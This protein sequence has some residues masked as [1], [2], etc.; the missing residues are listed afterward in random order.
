MSRRRWQ[1][2]YIPHRLNDVTEKLRLNASSPMQPI[3]WLAAITTGPS[4]IP[5]KVGI[6][7]GQPRPSH[8]RRGGTLCTVRAN[9]RLATHALRYA[10]NRSVVPVSLSEAHCLGL[11][12]IVPP[13]LPRVGIGPCRTG[14]QTKNTTYNWVCKTHYIHTIYDPNVH[15]SKVRVA[16]PKAT[17][18]NAHCV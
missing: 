3:H 14:W 13:A 18:D 16:L 7:G 8:P 11:D 4:L 9:L 15:L 10:R 2:D 12:A 6:V 1:V 5:Y 17:E